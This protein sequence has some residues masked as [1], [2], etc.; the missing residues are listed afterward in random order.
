[1]SAVGF[2]IV[3]VAA[4]V[5]C[6]RVA[7]RW[8][9][10]G[11]D[12]MAVALTL[13][14]ALAAAVPA[15][16]G[17]AGA[18]TSA[19]A[20]AAATLAVAIPAAWLAG[21]AGGSF[22]A[23]IRRWPVAAAGGIAFVFWGYATAFPAVRTDA[24]HLAEVVRWL[25]GGHPGSVELTVHEWPAGAYPKVNELILT[26]GVGLAR[27]F[28]PVAAWTVALLVLLA[29]SAYAGLRRRDVAPAAAALAA[30]T[31]LAVLGALARIEG[32]GTDLPSLAWLACAA[33]LLAAPERHRRHPGPAL[34]ALGL[35]LGTKLNVAPPAAA[36]AAVAVRDVWAT[37]RRADLVAAAAGALAG[38]FWPARNLVE[39]G[40]PLWPFSSLGPGDPVPGIL[41]G[42]QRPFVR[43]AGGTLDQLWL[44]NPRAVSALAI[45]L[46][47]ALAAPL[48]APR[49]DVRAAALLTFATLALW[50]VSPL[51]GR[52]VE[53]DFRAAFIWYLL[54]TAAAAIA[55]TGL[56]AGRP[57]WPGRAG[58][59]AL[60]AAAVSATAIE[61]LAS[62]AF[63]SP[64]QAVAVIVSGLLAGLVTAHALR[65]M[66][67]PGWS[68]A[69]L[70]CGV[71]AL[72]VQLAGPRYRD[73]G[74]FDPLLGQV[75]RVLDAQAGDSR[76]VVAEWRV[77]GRMAGPRLAH[78][79][80]LLP[81][82]AGCDE[83]RAL[84]QR[85]WLVAVRTERFP[86]VWPIAGVDACLRGTAPVMRNLAF[87]VYGPGSR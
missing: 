35:A 26:W 86:T 58:I 53:G 5:A 36:L 50:A 3:A 69:A 8:A 84:A 9:G 55:T 17:L 47:A 16:C 59:A 72:A 23:E 78:P 14:A 57:G 10:G 64:Q 19:V 41:A 42:L 71:L 29:G 6:V 87:A 32:A 22:A 85:S 79:I 60:A 38:G 76:P 18:G 20:F 30:A 80:A 39:H 21:P 31:L 51:S 70:A 52:L 77:D 62:P 45:L 54:P 66:K 48:L 27:A 4:W 61:P 63:A 11:W 68:V 2:G 34:L 40:S 49:R 33:A 74:A 1:M 67:V 75:L 37:R 12:R 25:H 28:P 24:F 7:G 65:R 81:L 44:E 43:D 73:S 15:A 82:D 46:V 83:I 13:M 56:L